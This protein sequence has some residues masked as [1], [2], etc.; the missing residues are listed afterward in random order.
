MSQ[1]V[2]QSLKAAARETGAGSLCLRHSYPCVTGI[3]GMPTN[4]DWLF[5]R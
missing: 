1:H 2:V 4:K 5:M 3:A